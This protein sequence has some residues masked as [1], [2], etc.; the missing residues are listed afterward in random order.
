[1]IRVVLADDHHV[2][3]HGL[4]LLLQAEPDLTV[5]GEAADGRATLALVETLSPNVLLLDLAM[6]GPGGLSVCRQVTERMPTVRVVVL[7]MYDAE[8]YVQEALRCGA[9]AYVL[10]SAR[11]AEIVTAIREAAAGRHFLSPPLSERMRDPLPPRRMSVPG[12]LLAAL[13]TREREVFGL[14]AEGRTSGEIAEFL[15]IGVRTVETHRANLMHKLGLSNQSELI[16]LALRRGILSK[17]L[18]A[19]SL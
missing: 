7:S 8:P 2:V 16:R 18:S 5:V 17:D 3:R 14:V 6:P 15:G 9:A 13:T 4:R 10:K 1:M 19:D 11:P 12:D